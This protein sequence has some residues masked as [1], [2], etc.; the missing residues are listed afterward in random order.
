M[1]CNEGIPGIALII[2]SQIK[3][4]KM[5]AVSFNKVFD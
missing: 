4:A 3:C 2:F 1:E 5:G